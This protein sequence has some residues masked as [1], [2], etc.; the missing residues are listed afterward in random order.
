MNL[1]RSTLALAV[2][3]VAGMTAQAATI[4]IAAASDLKFAMDEIV[5]IFRKAHPLDLIDITY[6]SSGRFHTQ[7]QQGAPFDLFFSADIS[8][9][10]ELAKSGLAAS[11]VKPY[12]FGRIVLWSATMDASK[13]TLRYL[14]DPGITR[15]AIANP[16]HAPYG[17]RA[18]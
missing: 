1:V 10:Q 17:K 4:R 7:I 13:M 6:G 15:I 5:G 3:L 8:L 11:E 9:P 18:E 2:L 12:A 16:K 14:T